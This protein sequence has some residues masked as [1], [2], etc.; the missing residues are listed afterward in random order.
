MTKQEI[1]HSSKHASKQETKH[2]SKQATSN[3]AC[4]SKQ[5]RQHARKQDSKKS[6]KQPHACLRQTTGLPLAKRSAFV[7]AASGFLP[8]VP[9]AHDRGI[10]NPS[11]HINGKTFYP[12]PLVLSGEAAKIPPAGNI[13]SAAQ[14]YPPRKVR[15]GVL[16]C[17][18]KCS[19]N[20]LGQK[21]S[22]CRL[23][24]KCLLELPWQISDGTYKHTDC[25]ADLWLCTLF[26]I[27]PELWKSAPK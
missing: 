25:G 24:H 18:S 23:I 20:A 26:G 16:A 17:E 13:D 21:K 12:C 8:Q 9:C 27:A 5:A 19:R 7:Q 6:S 4:A 15:F 22:P 11:L 1:K 3:H 10:S 2:A 14:G